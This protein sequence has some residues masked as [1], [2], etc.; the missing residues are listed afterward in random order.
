MLLVNCAPPSFY[1][2]FNKKEIY[3]STD[4]SSELE[5]QDGDRISIFEDLDNLGDF[6]VMKTM[7]GLPIKPRGKS[8][9]IYNAPLKKRVLRDLK[10]ENP[11]F[12]V[13]EPVLIDGKKAFPI[14]TRK[15]INR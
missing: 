1:V 9:A 10:I 3:L 5:L 4:L 8:Y 2:S 13:G 14:I 11:C 7:L 15:A 12:A 6:Y